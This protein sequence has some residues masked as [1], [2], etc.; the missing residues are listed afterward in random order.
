MTQRILEW[1]TSQLSLGLPVAIATVLEVSGS[2]P[3]KAGARIAL[4]SSD[5]R[6]T[7][8]GAGLELTVISRLQEM[9]SSGVVQGEVATYGLQKGAKGHEVV[10]L[11][12]LCGGR[13]T[14][15]LEVVM[16]MPNILLMGG[17]HVAKAIAH[18]CEGLGWDHSV[19][20]TRADYA[21]AT[22]FPAA[23]ERHH[24]PVAEFLSSEDDESLQRFTDILL[25]GHDWKEDEERFL[26]LLRIVS[27]SVRL[28]VIGSKPKWQ[29]FSAVARKAGI[30][31]QVLDEVD[32]PIGLAIGA[33]SPAE[34]AVAVMG[35]VLARKKGLQPGA[36]NWRST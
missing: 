22:S 19:Q 31:Q 25:L 6:G 24:C 2:V 35:A 32:C 33:E 29:A 34:I 28:G 18:I 36:G 16:P 3:G 23:R 14:L 5:R 1:V 17:G 13:V 26:S 7:V 10:A 21:S 12:S 8:G 9:L 30:S 4:T 15:S 20:D 11:D 27:P